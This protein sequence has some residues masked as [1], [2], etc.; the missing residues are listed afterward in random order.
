MF[1][2]WDLLLQN[3]L[4]VWR[5]IPDRRQED[6]DQGVQDPPAPHCGGVQDSPALHDSKEE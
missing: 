3:N 1:F 5:N 2:F 6:V 4:M